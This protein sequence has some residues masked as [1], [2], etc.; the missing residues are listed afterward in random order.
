MSLKLT[1][2]IKKTALTHI[3]EDS[4]YNDS[5]PKQTGSQ[6]FFYFCLIRLCSL[7]L[8]IIFLLIN[9][10]FLFDVINIEKHTQYTPIKL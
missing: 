1:W 7:T 8:Q 2:S 3:L 9:L 6:F 10:Y 5:N 4:N